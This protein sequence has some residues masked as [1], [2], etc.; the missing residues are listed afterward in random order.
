M[1]C[2]GH[3]TRV[4]I[5]ENYNIKCTAHI[6]LLNEQ[7]IRSDAERD[8]TDT[9]YIFECVNKNDDNDVDRIVCGTGA[10][11]DLLQLANITAPP[12]FN[13]LH[14]G[15]GEGGA[16][17]A[18]GGNQHQDEEWDAAAKQLYN[19][20]MILITAW[21]LRPGPIYNYLEEARRYKRC[22]PYSYRVDRINQ[23]VHRHGTSLRDVLNQLAQNNNI[24]NYE[25]NLLE[26]ILH[27][28]GIVS[29]FEDANGRE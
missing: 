22:V 23:I 5:V 11:R 10:A 8:I 18:G 24:R 21:N 16:G 28:D 2:H 1:N 13:M 4:R 25:F 19:A 17:G 3:D 14:E 6:R 15:G 26:D 29:Y 12:I 20:I 9:Y 27:N 7:I